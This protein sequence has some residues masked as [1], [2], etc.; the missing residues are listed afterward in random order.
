MAERDLL[1]F[2]AFVTHVGKFSRPRHLK[3]GLVALA[4]LR[5]P[6]RMYGI[7]TSRQD[8]YVFKFR[9]LAIYPF[10]CFELGEDLEFR[11]FSR[12]KFRFAA[13]LNQ[14]RPWRFPE[15]RF[16]AATDDSACGSYA[17]GNDV[18]GLQSPT[19]QCQF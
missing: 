11:V 6:S 3:V 9:A 10:L 17:K 14:K 1:L 2:E 4:R 12:R 19:L 8:S 5:I 13:T 7:I 15:A 16:W 18:M